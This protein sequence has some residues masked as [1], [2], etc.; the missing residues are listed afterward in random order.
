MNTMNKARVRERRKRKMIGI[1]TLKSLVNECLLG[2][3][4]QILSELK[5]TEGMMIEDL[6]EQWDSRR[7]NACICQWDEM[8]D[9][10]TAR[11]GSDGRELC[12]HHQFYLKEMELVMALEGDNKLV[13]FA[14]IRMLIRGWTVGH[15]DRISWLLTLV[16]KGRIYEKWLDWGYGELPCLTVRLDESN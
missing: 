14:R 6:K 11:L 7:T 16:R 15:I 5:W 3:S 9:T 13:C 12:C 2:W 10:K 8:N 4:L 1:Y